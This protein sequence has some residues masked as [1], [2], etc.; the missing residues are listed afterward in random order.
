[1]EATL[2]R[3]TYQS[4]TAAVER[5]L[6]SYPQLSG[7]LQLS[8]LQNGRPVGTQFRA[9][10]GDRLLDHRFSANVG[11]RARLA[12]Q[13][14]TMAAAMRRS[15]PV[16]NAKCRA[17]NLCSATEYSCATACGALVGASREPGTARR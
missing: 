2:P 12:A 5:R 16:Q 6:A 3:A 7:Q 11:G 17:E 10:D 4:I 1:M 15:T 9:G 13:A 8:V 14:F